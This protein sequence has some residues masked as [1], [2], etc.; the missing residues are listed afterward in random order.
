M[1]KLNLGAFKGNNYLNSN[2]TYC[3][4]INI[5]IH[6]LPLKSYTF[7]VVT[8]LWLYYKERENQPKKVDIRLSVI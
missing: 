6:F 1:F 3:L 4:H 8:K 7:K 2:Y 5:Y